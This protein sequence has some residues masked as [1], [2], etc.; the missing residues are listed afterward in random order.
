M[1]KRAI[2]I[3][4]VILAV[5]IAAFVLL[6]TGNERDGSVIQASGTIEVTEVNVAFK[7]P[8][9]VS[10]LFTD[11]GKVILRGDKLAALDSAEYASQ[12]AQNRAN[13]RN[14]EAQ[15]AK[16][17]NDLDRYEVLFKQGAISAQQIDSART[18]DEVA[19]TQEQ[20][21]D[22]A[23][24]TSEI[25]L[26]DT[27]I[28]APSAG[29]VLRKNIEPGETIAAGVPIVTIGV[30]DDPWVKV[31][32]RETVLGLV[33]LGQKAQI[34]T[35]TYPG[36]QYE[37]TV[38]YI[39]SEAEFTPKNVQTREERTKLVFGVKI[40]VKN[41]KNELKPGMPADVKILLNTGTANQ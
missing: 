16:A 1:N 17:K 30:L 39:S 22:A 10:A 27:V 11:E 32:I 24:R 41:E 26:A 14:T 35:D 7:I 19:R 34:W 21:A 5:A 9:R 40:R 38:T 4:S 13:Y 20:Q 18:G 12:V 15:R 25:R 8:G 28:F 37:G 3:V 31:Y 33:K 23:L 2:I 29:V 36:K 6:R